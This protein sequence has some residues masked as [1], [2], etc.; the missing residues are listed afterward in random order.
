MF[1][2]VYAFVNPRDTQTSA[3]MLSWRVHA[4]AFTIAAIVGGA[5]LNIRAERNWV[6]QE[7]KQR[8]I[9]INSDDLSISLSRWINKFLTKGDD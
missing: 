8:N 9:A 1:S 4:Q 7:A 3:R 6:L 5:Y 2:L